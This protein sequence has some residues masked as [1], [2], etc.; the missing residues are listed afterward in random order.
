MSKET[1]SA[2]GSTFNPTWHLPDGIE[3]HI[4][5]GI[6]NTAIGTAVGGIAGL[7]LFRSGGGWRAFSMASGAGIAMGNTFERAR[8]SYKTG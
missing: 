2:E 4:E 5:K 6:I 1:T 7:I 3:N 8:A